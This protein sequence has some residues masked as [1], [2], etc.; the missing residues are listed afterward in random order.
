M[1]YEKARAAL[2]KAGFAD[3]ITLFDVDTATVALAARAVGVEEARIAKTLAFDQDGKTV[4]IVAAG[5]AKI[6]NRKY[7]DTFKTKAKMLSHED[8]AQRTGHA[9]GG[10]CPFGVDSSVEVFLDESLRRF[11]VVYPAAGTSNSAVR[12]ALSELEA[13]V[14]GARWV[15]VAKLPV[16]EA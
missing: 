9:V 4:L 10:V 6:D 8:T 12:L 15:D 7:K 11:D 1:S 16:Q 5:D 2:E 3:R 13:A 14:P